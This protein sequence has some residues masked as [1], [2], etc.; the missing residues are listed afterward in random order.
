[1]SNLLAVL[2][3]LYPFYQHENKKSSLDFQENSVRTSQ[4][5]AMPW[6]NVCLKTSKTILIIQQ[7]VLKA[8]NTFSL[9]II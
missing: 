1:M 8:I 3:V 6:I 9:F 5:D 4:I 2:N 7:A